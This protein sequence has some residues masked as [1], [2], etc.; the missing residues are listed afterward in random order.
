MNHEINLCTVTQAKM[1]GFAWYPC[2]PSGV[3]DLKLSYSQCW[4][5]V[6]AITRM[7]K[8]CPFQGDLNIADSVVI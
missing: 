1:K 7:E 8:L 4:D 6:P 5:Y 2:P 3:R